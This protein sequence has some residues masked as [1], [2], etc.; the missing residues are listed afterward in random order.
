MTSCTGNA[1]IQDDINSDKTIILYVVANNNL[2]PSA[3]RLLDNLEKY[4]K[5][6]YASLKSVN[7]IVLYNSPKGSILLVNKNKYLERVKSYGTIN[8][9]SK[10][11]M[12]AVLKD[13]DKM[14]PARENGVIFWSHGTGW[15]T[16]GNT[17][18]FGDDGGEAIEITDMAESLA[19]KYDYVIFDACYMG[20]IEVATAFRNKCSYFL[21]SP[22]AIPI[23]GII[24]TTTI[25]ILV[26][27]NP[28]KE[29]LINTCEAFSHK[30]D[31]KYLPVTVI[32]E[33]KID[34]FINYVRDLNIDLS[35]ITFEQLY[36]YNFRGY[37]IYFDIK[38]L[39]SQLEEKTLS[40]LSNVILY[41]SDKQECCGVSIF[42]P[43]K[44]NVNYWDYYSIIEWNL[45]TNWLSKWP[46]YAKSQ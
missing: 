41:P 46:D 11:N 16:A 15:L 14:F 27:D 30:M 1:C 32:D 35:N 19:A 7:L 33:G 21:A 39:F 3:K 12:T 24:D 13:I 38:T 4:I 20:S 36:S 37:D 40:T 17:R 45:L 22:D 6:N 8:S 5:E 25:S 29:R 26:Q 23:D 2:N 18:S 31:R 42:I 9:L 10:E 44:G 28:L 34:G 43:Q